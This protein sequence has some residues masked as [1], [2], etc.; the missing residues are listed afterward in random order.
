M[1]QGT[2]RQ[3]H[4][5]RV[6]TDLRV[7][8]QLCAYTPVLAGTFPLDLDVPGSDLDILCYAP[9]LTRLDADVRAA[10]GGCSEFGLRF[11]DKEGIPSLIAG[12]IS[13]GLPI[14]LFGQ[15]V[16][17][18]AQRG[19]R[20]L[21][22]EARLLRLGGR[23][24]HTAIRTL[25]AAGWKTEP[26]FAHHFGLEGDPYLALLALEVLDDDALA[27]FVRERSGYVHRP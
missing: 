8:E 25:R 6:L 15:P 23:E 17:V 13:D 21:R 9:D 5:V 26:A 16:P 24:T 27:R 18:P 12:F 3:R 14:E 1:A 4:A 19:Y 22:M 11:S 2:A 10:Y 7:C 20:H